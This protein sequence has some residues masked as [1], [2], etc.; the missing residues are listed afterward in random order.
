MAANHQN[1]IKTDIECTDEKEFSS[2][3]WTGCV[4]NGWKQVHHDCWIDSALYSLFSSD[5]WIVFSEILDSMNRSKNKHIKSIAKSLSNY[6]RYINEVKIADKTFKLCKQSLKNKIVDDYYHYL[7]TTDSKKLPEYVVPESLPHR[8]QFDPEGSGMIGFGDQN[9]I[10][11]L[12][13]VFTIVEPSGF[14]IKMSFLSNYNGNLKGRL[15]ELLRSVNDNIVFI[16][17]PSISRDIVDLTTSSMISSIK[18][19]SL[20]GIIT[21][22]DDHIVT[23][24]WCNGDLYSYDNQRNG[25]TSEKMRAPRFHIIKNTKTGHNYERVILLYKNF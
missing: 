24:N 15:E 7:S 16:D 3:N 14:T 2:Y 25:S 4:A 8:I 19:Y 9:I 5:M 17:I 6:L 22:T 20:T 10:L 1:K 21:G 13:N 12:F 18:G 23:Y 11:E